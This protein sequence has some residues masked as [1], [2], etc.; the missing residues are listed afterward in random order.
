MADSPVLQH[1]PHRLEL[2]VVPPKLGLVHGSTRKDGSLSSELG[3][4]VPK[5]KDGRWVGRRNGEGRDV[6]GDWMTGEGRGR[7]KSQP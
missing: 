3:S 5:R 1:R 2:F 6:L 7:Q 4:A